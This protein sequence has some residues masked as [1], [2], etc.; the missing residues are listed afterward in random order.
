MGKLE[1][2]KGSHRRPGPRNLRAAAER[3]ALARA[4]GELKREA[5]RPIVD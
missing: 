1:V 5:Q 2:L 4:A 3:I